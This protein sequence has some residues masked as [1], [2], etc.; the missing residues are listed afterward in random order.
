MIAYLASAGSGP[1]GAL[2]RFSAFDRLKFCVRRLCVRSDCVFP[3][4]LA[5]RR[6]L[7]LARASFWSARA[8][9]SRPKR[10]FFRCSCVRALVRS[11]HAAI[12]LRTH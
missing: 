10:L 7:W 2:S 3:L 5:V 1:L 9:F 4:D 12:V 11:E 6:R 8:R